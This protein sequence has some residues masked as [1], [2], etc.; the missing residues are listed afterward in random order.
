MDDHIETKVAQIEGYQARDYER[1]DMRR[2]C[3]EILD[4]LP[5]V[6]EYFG[7]VRAAAL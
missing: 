5:E 3:G 7:Y 4:M 2:I 1:I 6:K